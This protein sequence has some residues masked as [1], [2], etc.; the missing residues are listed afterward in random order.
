MVMTPNCNLPEG[1][2]AEAAIVTDADVES[3]A[4]ALRQLISMSDAELESAGTRGRRLVEEQ[5]QWPRIVRQV[6]QVYDWILGAGPK[7]AC[8][9]S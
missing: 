5:F 3:I 1:A 9:M 7:P 4:V 8:I 2:K 6:T